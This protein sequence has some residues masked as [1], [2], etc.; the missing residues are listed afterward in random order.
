MCNINAVEDEVIGRNNSG[1][2]NAG[3][4]K[5]LEKAWL[6]LWSRRERLSKV[7]DPSM[8]DST[9]VPAGAKESKQL[10]SGLSCLLLPKVS[11]GL[12]LL[13]PNG[14]LSLKEKVLLQ[15]FPFGKVL[16]GDKGES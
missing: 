5:R 11:G 8:A 3:R 7:S 4:P 15:F 16:I 12:E 14:M 10:L 2:T 1:L 6:K 13:L 9:D